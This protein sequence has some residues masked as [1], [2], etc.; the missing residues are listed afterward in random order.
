MRPSRV[1]KL[2]RTTVTTE[3]MASPLLQ[4]I[5]P[6]YSNRASRLIKTPKIHFLDS[7]LLSA[8]RDASAD[9][10]ERDRTAFGPLLE[11]FVTSEIMKLLSWGDRSIHLS[12]F[13]TK[14][15]DEVDLVLECS[16]R[17]TTTTGSRRTAK[18]SRARRYPCSGTCK[19][20]NELLELPGGLSCVALGVAE[21]L[22]K[23]HS[24]PARA[25]E[26]QAP[27]VE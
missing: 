11:T 8:L 22:W 23:K 24:E 13:R 3:A 21:A 2:A 18:K 27:C 20:H 7:G 12:Y 17:R 14:D 4:T 5:R 19:S 16:G 1:A 9:A 25:G 15:Y 6:W 10:F 26:N